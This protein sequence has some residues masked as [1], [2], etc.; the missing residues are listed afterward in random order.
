MSIETPTT[1]Q[2]H[3]RRCNPKQNYG[4]KT[5]LRRRS[6]A[7]IVRLFQA[8]MPVDHANGVDRESVEDAAVGVDQG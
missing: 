6:E 2:F 1:C 8:E 5:V 7:R 3:G 4:D